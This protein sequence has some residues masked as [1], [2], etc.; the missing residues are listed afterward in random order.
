MFS[1]SILNILP[2]LFQT[3][4]PLYRYGWKSPI[5]FN[6]VSPKRQPLLQGWFLSKAD[7]EIKADKHTEVIW[8]VQG[9]WKG[10]GEVVRGWEDGQWGQC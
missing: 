3:Q 10:C 4:K 7:P 9:H 2:Y 8:E 6:L 5:P 1:L